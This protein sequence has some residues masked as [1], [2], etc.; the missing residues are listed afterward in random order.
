MVRLAA[1]HPVRLRDRQILLSSL[2]TTATAP[3]D[4]HFR[5]LRL[6]LPIGLRLV[7][8]ARHVLASASAVNRNTHLTTAATLL[9][10]A[11]RRAWR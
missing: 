2:S 9:I 8:G 4:P 6:R 1:C 7:P 11:R 3:N 5:F 10:H